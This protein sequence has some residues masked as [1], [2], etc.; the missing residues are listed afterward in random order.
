MT[1]IS[2][3][4]LGVLAVPVVLLAAVGLWLLIGIINGGGVWK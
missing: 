3:I 2:V 1:C 4:W